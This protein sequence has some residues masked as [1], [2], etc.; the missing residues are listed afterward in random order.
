[1]VFRWVLNLILIGLPWTFLSQ[2]MFAW[3][4]LFNAKWNFLWDGGNVYLIAN[5]VSA[6]I[7]TWMS[8]LVI[9]EIPFHMRHFK[10][11]ELLIINITTE[12]TSK[13]SIKYG[14]L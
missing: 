2:I 11:L 8:V 12:S 5:T 9:W 6:Y 14:I 3:N 1:M 4:A 7:Q 13:T 10:L